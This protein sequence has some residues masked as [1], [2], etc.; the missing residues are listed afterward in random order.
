M[1][2]RDFQRK[3]DE[4]LDA[5]AR[6]PAPGYG[7][8]PDSSELASRSAVEDL[9]QALM[10]HAAGC[11]NCRQ[12]AARYHVLRRA[13]RAWDA[14]PAP[15]ADLADRI[16]AAARGRSATGWTVDASSR[17]ERAW[18][19]VVRM[20]AS[21]TA[22]A[23]VLALLLSGINGMIGP[24]RRDRRPVVPPVVDQGPVSGRHPGP[25]T[26]SL[27]QPALHLAVAEA[28]SATWDLA[29]SASEPAARI[30]RDFLDATTRVDPVSAEPA[31]SGGPGNATPV[32]SLIPQAPDSA[33]ASAVFQQVGDHL[34]A[35]V[36]PL[37]TTARQAFGFLL[38]PERDR[39]AVRARPPAEKGA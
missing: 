21:F 22:A 5:E 16:L 24:A 26:G 8:G 28:T 18:R 13:L 32:S 30:S 10:D 11:P 17:P 12:L 36:R 39:P 9:D 34:A 14:L 25:G 29:R 2:C 38:G 4:L 20:L 15:P 31:S 23:V 1:T 37:S 3:W 7:E 6:P 19:P 35:G 33:A 27:D